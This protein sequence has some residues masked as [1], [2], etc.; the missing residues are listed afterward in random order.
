MEL[1]VTNRSPN[2]NPSQVPCRFA[3]LGVLRKQECERVQVLRLRL[4]VRVRARVRV[5]G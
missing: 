1:R 3:N 5:K 2:P 4:K